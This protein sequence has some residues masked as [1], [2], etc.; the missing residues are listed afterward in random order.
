MAVNPRLWCSIRQAYRIS[1]TK[2]SMLLL[3]TSAASELH[4][5][6]WAVGNYRKALRMGTPAS[7]SRAAFRYP[8]FRYFIGYRVLSVLSSEMQ[9]VAVGW[10][11][12]EL[13]RQPLDLGF[14]GL[15][16][17]LPGI[18]LFLVAGHAADRYDRRRLILLCHCGSAACSG[19]L[20]F[21]TLRGFRSAYAIYGVLFFLGVVR[22][23]SATATR[24]LLPQLVPPKDFQNAV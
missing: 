7:D 17:F 5:I 16:Q 12:Y 22:S 8:D 1:A 3:T 6:V 4:E 11:V 9:A 19:A 10:Q 15:A 18:L 20:L 24:S 23:F 13:T 2:L 14:V 21:L